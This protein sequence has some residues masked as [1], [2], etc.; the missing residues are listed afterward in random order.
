MATSYLATRQAILFLAGFFWKSNDSCR[1][2]SMLL[3]ARAAVGNGI[4]A[5]GECTWGLETVEQFNHVESMQAASRELIS[6]ARKQ[7][8]DVGSIHNSGTF[9]HDARTI[10][11]WRR[12]RVLHYSLQGR[13]DLLPQEYQPSAT[14]FRGMWDEAGSVEY[15]ASV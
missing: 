7:G 9:T 14:A 8:A 1:F 15:G 13:I 3:R 6:L 12:N 4:I 10:W 2:T 11:F 5:F